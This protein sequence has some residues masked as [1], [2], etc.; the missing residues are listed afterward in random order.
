MMHNFITGESFAHAHTSNPL[1][2]HRIRHGFVSRG[3]ATKEQAQSKGYR[4]RP[5]QRD[6]YAYVRFESINPKKYYNE[7]QFR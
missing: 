6:L 1:A 2:E 5:G 4:L 7:E 3:Y